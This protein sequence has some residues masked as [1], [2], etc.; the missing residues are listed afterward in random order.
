MVVPPPGAEIDVGLKL[1]VRPAGAP[2]VEKA[3]LA[4]NPANAAVVTVEVFD[5]P[6][7]TF[8]AVG[9]A[10]MLKSEVPETRSVTIVLRVTLPP[11]PLTVIA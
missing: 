5:E 1:T 9:E 6:C 3:T 2:V 4:L 7:T 10:P 11:V 8:T